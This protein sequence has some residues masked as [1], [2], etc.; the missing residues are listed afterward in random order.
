MVFLALI[1]LIQIG[2]TIDLVG[3]YKLFHFEPKLRTEISKI[4]WKR[5]TFGDR[6]YRWVTDNN[7]PIN[8]PFFHRL[9][10]RLIGIGRSLLKFYLDNLCLLWKFETL[11]WNLVHTLIQKYNLFHLAY[12][13]ESRMLLWD[14]ALLVHIELWNWNLLSWIDQSL[15]KWKL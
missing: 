10:G 13:F 4:S 6:L 1:W 2:N 8:R 15:A 14:V 5:A 3:N 12:I 11:F 9:I 7:R